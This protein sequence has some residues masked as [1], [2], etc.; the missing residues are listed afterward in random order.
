MP[1]GSEPAREL[2]DADAR[3]AIRE[4]LGTT[5]LVEA[6]AGTGKTT[7]LVDRMVALVSTGRTTVDRLSAVTF[8]IRAAA[9]LRQR[10][11]I[12]LEQAHAGERNRGRRDLLAAGLARLD[13]CFL[14]TIHAFSARLLRERPVEAGVDPGYREMDDPE[15]GAARGEA[16]ESYV[17]ALFARDDPRLAR[18]MPLGVPLRDLFDTYGALCEN[19]DIEAAIGAELPEPDFGKARSRVEAFLE[20]SREAVP[21]EAPEGGWTG[22]QEALRQARRRLE[23]LGPESPA[24]FARILESFLGEQAEKKAGPWKGRLARFREE[25]VEPAL[26]AWRE[27]LHPIILPLLA[28]ARDAYGQ[29]RRERGLANFQDLLLIARNL[30]RDHP[31]VREALRARFTPILVDE[32][33]D[34]DPIQ[35]EILFYLTGAE[36]DERDW[37]KL[38]PVPGALFVVGDP[39][40]SIYRFRRADIETYDI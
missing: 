26:R 24:G 28:G 13:S 15:D 21:P 29:W 3:R 19:S 30:L 20:E 1:K 40:Q 36:T 11:Q 4:D 25:T 23:L 22:F 34:T 14:G 8:T 17:T 7:S 27:Y 6:A 16:W 2:P 12:A 5:I 10:F 39:K 18:L 33:Q 37:R 31:Q 35:A 9:Q 32:F 38:T